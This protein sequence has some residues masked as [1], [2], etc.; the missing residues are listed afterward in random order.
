MSN[1]NNHFDTCSSGEKE[2]TSPFRASFPPRAKDEVAGG[3]EDFDDDV[4]DEDPV[5][6]EVGD[7]VALSSTDVRLLLPFLPG[8]L[9]SQVLLPIPRNSQLSTGPTASCRGV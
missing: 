9:F 8:E 6:N 5:G 2:T 1:S 4:D 7:E 3:N